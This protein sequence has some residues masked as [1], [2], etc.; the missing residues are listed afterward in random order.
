MTCEA[1]D[2][3]GLQAYSN[4]SVIDFNKAISK[5]AKGKHWQVALQLFNELE[6]KSLQATAVTYN[7]AIHACAQAATW[8]SA[9]WLLRDLEDQAGLQGNVISYSTAISSCEKSGQWQVALF[10]LKTLKQ[11]RLQLNV[12]AC[13]A[14]MSACAK[15]SLS[16]I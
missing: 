6:L 12:I 7:S 5:C 15:G 8:E 13:N 9:I 10:L 3:A 4:S 14:V 1:K 16:S 11:K 2:V